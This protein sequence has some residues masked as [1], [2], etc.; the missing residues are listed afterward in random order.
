MTTYLFIP[1][2]P[3]LGILCIMLLGSCQSKNPSEDKLNQGLPDDFILFYDSFHNDVSYQKDHV[4]FPLEYRGTADSI[5]VWTRDNW[6]AHKAFDAEKSELF[7][8]RFYK[9][10]SSIIGE[11]ISSPSL[12]LNLERRW[13]KTGSEWLLIYYD[14][15][16]S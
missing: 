9:M 6:V 7:N 4:L 3:T 13:Q 14:P 16:E 10:G 2:R 1:T 8:Q 5:D 15:M 11:E 12:Q